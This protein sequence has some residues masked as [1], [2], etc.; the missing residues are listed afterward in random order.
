M[1]DST[2]IEFVFEIPTLSV[3]V[4]CRRWEK[5]LFS[6]Q[7]F[8][9]KSGAIFFWKTHFLIFSFLHCNANKGFWKFQI[10]KKKNGE[11]IIEQA[12]FFKH[13]RANILTNKNFKLLPDI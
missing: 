8:L 12:D 3:D 2:F 13:F 7:I 4:I 1:Y 11:N 6:G 9:Y 10:K 5:V